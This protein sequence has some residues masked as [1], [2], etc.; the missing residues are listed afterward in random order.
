MSRGIIT[1]VPAVGGGMFLEAA[2][3]LEDPSPVP[4]EGPPAAGLGSSGI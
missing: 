4:G 3:G 1:G 2:E